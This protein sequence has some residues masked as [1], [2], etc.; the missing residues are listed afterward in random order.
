M[1]FDKRFCAQTAIRAGL[2]AAAVSVFGL[3]PVHAQTTPVPPAAE[4][5]PVRRM[6]IDDAVAT[7][8]EQNLDLQV[9]RI[10][11][12][13]QDLTIAQFKAA[14]TP[15]FVSTVNTSDSTQPST[16]FLSGN[17]GGI[18]SGRSQ[19]NFG[20]A[21]LT[22]WYGG[23]Y[24]IRWNNA[25]NT[26]NNL[27]STFNPQINSSLSAT[28][29]QPLLRNFKINGAHQQLWVSQRN[30]E[31]TDVQLQQSI[32]QTTRNVRNAYYDL[33]YAIGNLAVQRQSLQLAQQSLKDN[34]A[35]VEIGTMAPLD[36]VQ[37]E[38]EVATREESVIIAEAAIE[39][40]QDIIRALI[41]NPNSAEFWTARIE[42]TD[43]VTFVPTT[44][45]RE[46]AVK[47]ALTQRT[48]VVNA[49]KN[50]EINDF[51]IRYFRNQSL[52]DVTASVNYNANA[53]AGT[54]V[55]RARDP[56]TGLPTGAIVSSSS[57]SFF[58]GLSNTFT[59]DFP[60]WSVQ[61]DIAYPLG[62]S[63][64]E[65]QLARARLA[66]TQA[67]RQVSSL[68]MAVTNQVRDAARTVETNAKR[69]EATRSSRVL[70]ERRLEAEE[71]RYQA[72]LT[73]NFFVLQAQRDLNI[74][75]NS[76]LLALVEYAKS[77]V[78]FQAVQQVPLAGGGGGGVTQQQQ[79]QQQQQ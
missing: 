35:R 47:N 30:R 20:V 70:A 45:D 60:G 8:L 2:M 73:Q 64:Q 24:D 5:G 79:Q 3:S 55:T 27:F 44:V 36:I 1:R 17:T 58:N 21:S 15:N 68:E 69:V 14:Y 71:K 77:V 66:Q 67:Q 37:A 75:R 26:T 25:R 16:S 33:I 62:R 4:Q 9:Q 56:Q 29:S 18:T 48:D 57:V 52:P 63:T 53:I 40:Q 13:L 54:Q 49:R 72:G 39:R 11:P 28:F 6:S 19:F 43:T 46:M 38:A 59:G 7:A 12:Q 51:N 22:S 78:N 50:L 41:Y 42:P 31:I 34:R 74:A 32:A 61:F 65:A 23:S 10:N 76:E